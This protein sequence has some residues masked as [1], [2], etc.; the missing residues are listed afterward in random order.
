MKREI[1]DFEIPNAIRSVLNITRC[2]RYAFSNMF[3][4]LASS[5]HGA[6]ARQASGT[7]SECGQQSSGE[8]VT[9]NTGRFGLHN[10]SL[11]PHVE[12]FHG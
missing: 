2:T 3:D 11:C 4:I 5:F 1:E 9:R 7:Q 12:G 10:V 8:G 6:A